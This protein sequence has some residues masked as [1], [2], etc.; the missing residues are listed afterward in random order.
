MATHRIDRRT[1][2]RQSAVSMG[3]TAGLLAC[4]FFGVATRAAASEDIRGTIFVDD[5]PPRPWR[6]SKEA[7]HYQRLDGNVVRCGLCPHHCRLSP[8]DRSVCRARVNLK[9]TLY[10]LSYGNP[11][12]VHLDPIEKKPLYHF[13][14]QTRSFSIA[15]AGCNLRC[16]NCQNWEISQARPEDIRHADLFPENVVDHA[17]GA[18]AASIA[19]TY[20]EPTSFYEYMLDTAMLAAECGVHNLLISAGYIN[21]G[22]L[23]ELARWIDAANINL[24]SYSDEIYRRLNGARLKPVLRTLETLHA[25]GV[26]LEV[27]HLVVPGYVDDPGLFERMCRWLV[28]HLGPDH[29]L[30]LLRFFPRYRLERLAPTPVVTLERFRSIAMATGLHYV[31]IGNVPGHPGNHTYCHQ[32]GE[33]L[34]ERRGY[35]MP[36]F[37][38]EGG[39]CR[40]CGTRIAGVWDAF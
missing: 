14:P 8:G 1:F 2:L 7:L 6:W 26:H 11:C 25:A 13:L 15:A 36:S 37:H 5:A 30:H 28:D 27:T 16:L 21:Q 19:Y 22:P 33:R 32:C 40:F 12:A 35:R 9:G 18:D 3:A 39:A 38:I 24:K 31:Y 4:P 10:S 17:L 29:P 34:V 23:E 20:S